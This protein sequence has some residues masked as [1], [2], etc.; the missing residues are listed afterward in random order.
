M[1]VCITICKLFFYLKNH[2]HL[3][4]W[5]V[6]SKSLFIFNFVYLIN[7]FQR[8]LLYQTVTNAKLNTLQKIYFSFYQLI[9]QLLIYSLLKSI[10]AI[11]LITLFIWYHYNLEFLRLVEFSFAVSLGLIL[12]S[13]FRSYEILNVKKNQV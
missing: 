13:F 2:I 11:K 9:L 8:R 12:L 10:I 5:L 3:S 1:Y 6:L 7:I 4:T